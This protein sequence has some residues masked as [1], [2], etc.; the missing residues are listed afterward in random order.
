MLAVSSNG[1]GQGAQDSIERSPSTTESTK[2]NGA[3][4]QHQ[5][6][7]GSEQPPHQELPRKARQVFTDRQSAAST[8]SGQE[9]SAHH[10]RHAPQEEQPPTT[11]TKGKDEDIH[12][13]NKVKH[14]AHA[15]KI[16]RYIFT[17]FHNKTSGPI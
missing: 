10:L 16:C 15:R 2:N 7:K 12:P 11:T 4:T 5:H 9:E 17:A 1:A 8:V 3:E 14:K 6:E 13:R